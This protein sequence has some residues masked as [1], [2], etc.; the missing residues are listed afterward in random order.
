MGANLWD[1]S[2]R[3]VIQT[4]L[5][6]KLVGIK[7]GPLP[8]GP[9]LDTLCIYFVFLRLALLRVGALVNESRYV[10]LA[11]RRIPIRVS[12]IRASAISAEVE[13]TARTNEANI[14]RGPFQVRVILAGEPDMLAPFTVLADPVV[15]V[16]HS[17]PDFVSC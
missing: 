1:P 10:A 13:K 16:I 9:K 17:V 6:C 11:F 4:G 3:F 15:I 7:N 14:L 12:V 5:R 8:G 2:W